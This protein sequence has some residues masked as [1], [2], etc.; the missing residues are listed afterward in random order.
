MVVLVVKSAKG[1][2]EAGDVD[3][4]CAMRRELTLA[5][6]VFRSVDLGARKRINSARGRFSAGG[7]GTSS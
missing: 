3:E 2:T 5:A 6:F 4:W 1:E 7:M